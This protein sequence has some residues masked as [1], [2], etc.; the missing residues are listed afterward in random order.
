M[1]ERIEQ[2]AWQNRMMLDQ[3]NPSEQS[4]V[5]MRSGHG[6]ASSTTSLNSSRQ[7]L[8]GKIV[9]R[10]ALISG[11][12][13]TVLPDKSALCETMDGNQSKTFDKNKS[14]D[15]FGVAEIISKTMARHA[16]IDL[17]DTAQYRSDNLKSKARSPQTGTIHNVGFDKR[18]QYMMEKEKSKQERLERERRLQ[19]ERETIE[20]T[21]KPKILK[22]DMYAI[23]NQEEGSSKYSHVNL[24]ECITNK[25]SLAQRNKNTS[26]STIGGV[27]EEY[28]LHEPN[29]SDNID[30]VKASYS[31]SSTLPPHERLWLLSE[32]KKK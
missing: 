25:H 7:N 29:K 26:Q 19:A 17:N 18:V 9:K 12:E 11:H 20:C 16:E 10:K 30:F 15:L 14:T 1:S 13:S 21:F 24:S 4:I 22:S 32:I 27:C 3:V 2:K 8:A 23:S 28:G 31:I 5:T 6:V